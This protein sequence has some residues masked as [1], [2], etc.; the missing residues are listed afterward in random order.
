MKKVLSKY[1]LASVPVAAYCLYNSHHIDDTQTKLNS[2]H[3]TWCQTKSDFP[4]PSVKASS[5]KNFHL[6]QIQV[7]FRHGARTPI[8]CAEDFDNFTNLEPV[9]WDKERWK[10]KLHHVDVEFCLEDLVSGEIVAPRSYSHLILPGGCHGGD[11]TITGQQEGFEFGNWLARRY[12]HCHGI[13]PAKY[14]KDAVYIRS[15]NTHRTVFTATSVVSGLFG[16]EN[17][18]EPVMIHTKKMKDDIHPNWTDCSN[19]HKRFLHFWNAV[20]ERQEEINQEMGVKEGARRFNFVEKYDL[21]VQRKHHRQPVPQYLLDKEEELGREAMIL[22]RNILGNAHVNELR[23]SVGVLIDTMCSEMMNMIERTGE[24]KVVFYASH[25]TT[26]LGILTALGLPDMAWP[27][28]VANIIFELHV[29][30]H[31]QR[32]VRVLHNGEVVIVDKKCGEEYM[33]AEDFLALLEK[34]RVKDWA[35][36]CGNT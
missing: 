6:E 28:F 14:S 4:L 7:L 36:E 32:F 20:S 9:T 3:G 10:R 19:L 31:Q 21:I 13:I 12:I 17:V 11:L 16:R 15:T 27:P 35:K 5:Q 2:P 23:N 8:K 18:N 30:E 1:L 22:L 24:K 26:V 34:Y 33:P 29:D 25:D